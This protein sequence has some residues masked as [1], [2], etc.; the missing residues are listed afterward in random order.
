MTTPDEHRYVG[1]APVE[2][3]AAFVVNAEA[4]CLILVI[5]HEGEI[6]LHAPIEWDIAAMA[7][8]IRA[9]A[10][11]LEAQHGKWVSDGMDRF[12]GEQT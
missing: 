2:T 10:D 6:S 4:A 7:R 9:A 12:T 1:P 3:P 8:A 5:S 11:S